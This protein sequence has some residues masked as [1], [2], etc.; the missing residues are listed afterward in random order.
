MTAR[1]YTY[2]TIMFLCFSIL[3]GSSPIAVGQGRD[4]S[5]ENLSA[6]EILNGFRTAALYLTADGRPLRSCTHRVH[7]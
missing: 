7:L 3:I 1:H 5:F 6:G 4:V 2:I